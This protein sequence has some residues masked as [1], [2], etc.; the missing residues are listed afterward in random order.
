[1]S[2]D[3][4]YLSA[5]FSATV[6]QFSSIDRTTL[7]FNQIHDAQ[8]ILD[9]EPKREVFAAEFMRCQGLFEFL[10]PNMKLKPIEE[11]Y[12]FLARIYSSIAPTNVADLL[13]WQR[14]GAKTMEIV[15]QH[16]KDVTIDSGQ[17]EK[18]AVDAGLLEAIKDLTL[19]SIPTGPGDK[20]PTAL[21]VMQRLEERIQKRFGDPETD[22]VWRSLSERLELLRL[23][24]IAGAAE[25]V[26]FLK[27]LLTLAKDLIEAERADDEGRI[28]DIKVVDP[29]KG[30]LSQIFQEY[31]PQD[32]PVVIETV[33][34]KVDA[35]VQPVRGTGWQTSHPGDRTVR[36]ELRKIL[37]DSGLPHQGDLFDHA[38]DY[39]RENY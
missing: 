35:L 16:L 37:R 36:L 31:K 17:L 8:Q 5:D 11:D 25:S 29:R 4:E 10:W 20:G 13:L 34:D 3:C 15:H 38:Y 33:V 9:T 28:S 14:L 12:R 7:V 32:V 19:F 26:E 30:A 21:E 1:L 23:S 24:R 2:Y 39:I 27:K 22:K 18:V 6:N